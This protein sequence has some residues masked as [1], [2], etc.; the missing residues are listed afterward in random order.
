LASIATIYVKIPPI[1]NQVRRVE[2]SIG[3]GKKRKK[4]QEAFVL[5]LD[6]VHHSPMGEEG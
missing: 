4:E 1:I 5:R 2:L 6:R 3:F